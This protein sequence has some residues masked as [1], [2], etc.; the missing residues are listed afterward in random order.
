LLLVKEA[1]ESIGETLTRR[2]Q[3]LAT[4]ESCTGGGVG[5]ALTSL[6]GSSSWYLGGVISY[7]NQLKI[8]LVHVSEETLMKFGAVSEQVAREMVEGI[9]QLTEADYAIS[10]TGI[11]GP[12]GGTSEKP[13]G[14]VCFGY[15]ARGETFTET[16]RFEGD[17]EQV[18]A[19]T[20][21]HALANIAQHISKK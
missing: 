19:Q 16:K 15:F 21:S 7:S 5:E 12:E 6:A 18:R 20:V 11:A 10:T 4:A 9:V 17:R 1:L 8:E 14:T 2:H 13:V 3:T